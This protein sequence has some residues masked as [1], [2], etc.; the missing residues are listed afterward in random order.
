M[1]EPQAAAHVIPPEVWERQSSR[2]VLEREHLFPTSF[3]VKKFQVR[4][5]G[6]QTGSVRY[7]GHPSEITRLDA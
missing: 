3:V 5:D 4:D 1:I 2:V 6:K 7:G